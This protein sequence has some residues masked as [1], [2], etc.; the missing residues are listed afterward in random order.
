[1]KNSIESYITAFLLIALAGL[2][3]FS[4]YSD[5]RNEETMTM[6]KELTVEDQIDLE[7]LSL[8]RQLAFEKTNHWN[9]R[10]EWDYRLAEEIVDSP[11][12][13]TW[14]SNSIPKLSCG[15]GWHMFYSNGCNG[16]CSVVLIGSNRIVAEYRVDYS[17]NWAE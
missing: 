7:I 6:P 4:I 3:A 14:K 8:H 1:M 11:Y 13:N 17:K 12:T 10:M 2:F 5:Y 9:K 15:L 16:P